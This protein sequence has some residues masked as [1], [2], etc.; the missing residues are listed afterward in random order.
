MTRSAPEIRPATPD[1][2]VGVLRVLDAGLLETDADTVRDRIA[3]ADTPVLVAD[4]DGRVVGAVVLGERPAWV[5]TAFEAAES[6]D[7]GHVDA[8]AVGRSRRGQGLGTA[9][10]RAGCESVEGDLTADFAAS[11]RPFYE[12]LGWRVERV[13]APASSGR[14]RERRLV[15][16]VNIAH[17]TPTPSSDG[18]ADG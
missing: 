10:L 14:S 18:D 3:D 12:S 17:T 7:G 13:D 6:R 1:D 5:A 9:L 11:V 15:A 8:V 2:L 16:R 4:A